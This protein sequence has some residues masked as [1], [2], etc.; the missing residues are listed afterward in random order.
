MKP[1]VLFAVVM[2]LLAPISHAA[3][4]LK[5][6]TLAPDGTS[7]MKA[8]RQAAAD[9]Q[10]DTAGRV[11]VKFF[12]GGVQGSDKSVLRKMQIRQ[13]QGGAVA[14]GSLIDIAPASQLY[15][16]PFTFR[17]LNEVRTIRKEFDPYIIEQMAKAGY[18][19]LGISE[20]GFAYMMSDKPIRSSSDMSDRKVWVPEG[21]LIGQTTFEKGN[22]NPVSLPI[23]DVYT[24]LQTGLI[25]TFVVNPSSAIAL[26]WHSKI[27]YV[28]DYPLLFLVGMIVIDDKSFAKLSA[29]DQASVRAVMAKAF[30]AMDA[31]NEKDEAGARDAM[32]QNGIEF[33]ELSAADKA[34]WQKLATSTVEELASREIYP[35]DVYRKM[36]QRLKEIRQE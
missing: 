14:A 22:V 19:V 18:V 33:V 28:T 13:L 34:E 3:T 31:Q 32:A 15:S 7:W 10:E 6:A 4:T 23:S 5:I 30:T 8:M 12:P 16:L 9:I 21:D 1:V 27:K 36:L 35:V 20:A 29:E 25:D 26:Q 11:K 2:S 24:S 17:N